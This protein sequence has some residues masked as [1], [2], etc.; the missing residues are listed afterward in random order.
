MGIVNIV[1]DE[2]W[3]LAVSAYQVISSGVGVS[4]VGVVMGVMV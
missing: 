4:P 3:Q 1:L 2:E